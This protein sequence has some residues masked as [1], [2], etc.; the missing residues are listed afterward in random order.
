MLARRFGYDAARVEE[1]LHAYRPRPDG[2]ADAALTHLYEVVVIA[3]AIAP[4]AAHT[5]F[6]DELRLRLDSLGQSQHDSRWT[7]HRDLLAEVRQRDST[8]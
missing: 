5:V 4:Y 1:V 7:P 3:G 8:G 6:E 2:E